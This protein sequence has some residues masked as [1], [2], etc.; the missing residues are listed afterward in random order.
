VVSGAGSGALREPFNVGQKEKAAPHNTS[1]AKPSIN[2]R[3]A[4][5]AA[6]FCGRPFAAQPAVAVVSPH[7][8]HV[9]DQGWVLGGLNGRQ[10]GASRQYQPCEQISTSGKLIHGVGTNG[11]GSATR[12]IKKREQD[13]RRNLL[14]VF[15]MNSIAV[16]ELAFGT[17]R[18]RPNQNPLAEYI[19]D[20]HYRR[21]HG[22][23]A[24]Y[25]PK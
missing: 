5:L 6:F 18:L 16:A 20:K 9:E 12:E 3:G 23:D 25:G 24:Y 4:R 11:S 22:P 7:G 15:G 14:D 21:K 2:R 17:L 13:S 10:H 1:A 19:R 8:I